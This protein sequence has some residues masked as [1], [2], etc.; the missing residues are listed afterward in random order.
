MMYE[1]VCC[2]HVR[3]LVNGERVLVGCGL[4]LEIAAEDVHGA[5]D[6][7]GAAEGLRELAGATIMRQK[8]W[9]GTVAACGSEMGAQA[10]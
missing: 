3:N 6:S 2:Q 10:S 1:Q 4:D 7:G 5:T 8:E 9:R